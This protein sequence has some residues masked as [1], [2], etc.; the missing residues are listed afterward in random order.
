[1]VIFHEFTCVLGNFLKLESIKM[2]IHLMSDINT[3]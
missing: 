1:M 3:I 2:Y